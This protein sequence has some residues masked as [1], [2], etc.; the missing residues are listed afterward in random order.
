MLVR[1]IHFAVPVLGLLAD[2]SIAGSGTVVQIIQPAP[3][4]SST[5]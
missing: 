2:P 1:K 4:Q 5:S 3:V